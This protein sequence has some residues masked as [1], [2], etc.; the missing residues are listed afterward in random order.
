MDPDKNV[1]DILARVVELIHEDPELHDA[2]VA[3]IREKAVH[4]QRLGE[5]A[6]ARKE[7]L[8]A[9]KE[10]VEEGTEG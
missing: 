7:K 9:E 3:L 5:L 8:E 10:P 2:V 4:E 6:V 1:T